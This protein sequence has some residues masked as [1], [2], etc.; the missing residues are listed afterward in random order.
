MLLS[1]SKS[2]SKMYENQDLIL[3]IDSNPDD[4]NLLSNILKS[5][6]FKVKQAANS[7]KALEIAIKDNPDLIF[8]NINI[9]D[10]NGYSVYQHLKCQETTGKIPIIFMGTQEQITEKVNSFDIVRG[11]C[12]I[13]PFQEDEIITQ[14]NNKLMVNALE[15][16]LILESQLQPFYEYDDDDATQPLAPFYDNSLPIMFLDAVTKV[17]NRRKF[18]EYLNYQWKELDSKQL[19]LSLLLCHFDLSEFDHDLNRY[20]QDQVLQEIAAAI[21]QVVKRS[22]D[23]VAR[24]ENNTFAVILSRTDSKGAVHVGKL[25]REKIDK[26]KTDTELEDKKSFSLNIGVATVVPSDKVTPKSLISL[27]EKAIQKSKKNRISQ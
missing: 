6:S 16:S 5:Q 17:A 26:V 2:Q 13:K 21:K 23:L 18:D 15:E 11:D 9:P 12:I 14:I 24:Y 1:I 27:V 10:I 7:H 19:S 4:L 3:L 20:K 22:T 25:I 8:M